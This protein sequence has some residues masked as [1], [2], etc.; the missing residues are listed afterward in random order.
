M[1]EILQKILG[2]FDS[3]DVRFDAIDNRLDSMNNRLDS[4]DNRLSGV[5]EGQKSLLREQDEMRKEVAFYYGSLM[6]KLDETKI[7]LSSELKHVSHIQKQHQDVLE[8][9]NERQQ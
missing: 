6:K 5:E 4:M 3:I 1:E 2:R 7:E 8:I 9:L